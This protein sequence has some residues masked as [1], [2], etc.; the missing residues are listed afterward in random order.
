MS[1]AS[2]RAPRPRYCALSND[3]LRAAGVAMPSW[4]DALRARLRRGE[5]RRTG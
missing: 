3:K 2:L 4:Q 1:D 5:R